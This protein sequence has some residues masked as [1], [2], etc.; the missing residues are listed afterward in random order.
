MI[1]SVLPF[2][3]FGSVFCAQQPLETVPPEAAQHLQAGVDLEKRNDLDAAIK[4]F[5]EVTRTAPDCATGFLSLGDTYMKKGEY[6][7]AIAP[8]KRAAEL[9]PDSSTTK[10][11]LG[12]ALLS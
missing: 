6:G 12:F 8:L 5:Q 1:T 4:E 2:V 11:L 9:N 7:K 3:L 10:R